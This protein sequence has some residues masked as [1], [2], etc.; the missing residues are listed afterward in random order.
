MSWRTDRGET[1]IGQGVQLTADS[2]YFWFFNNDNVEVVIKVLDGCTTNDRFWV[3]A[4]G[5]TNVEAE[6]TV[7][8]TELGGSA[9]YVNTLGSVFV[10]VL[11]IDAFATCP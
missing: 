2:G 6:I 3:F 5:L 11:D 9:T 4:A 10:P 8:D 7:T 1:G